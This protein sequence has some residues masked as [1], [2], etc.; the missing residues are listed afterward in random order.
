[1]ANLTGSSISPQVATTRHVPRKRY[2]DTPAATGAIRMAVLGGST[3]NGSPYSDVMGSPV[4]S[5]F[6]LLSVTRY[7]LEAC[8]GCPAAD[9]DNYAGPNWSAATKSANPAPMFRFP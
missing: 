5:A 8:C 7:L 2:V 4:S 3:S 6:N 1:M 9:I